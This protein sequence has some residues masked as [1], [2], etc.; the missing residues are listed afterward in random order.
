MGSNRLIVIEGAIGVGK[1]TLAQLLAQELKADLLLEKV[2]ENPFLPKFYED[3]GKWA[4]QTQLFFL[5]SR[6]RQLEELVQQS[7]YA[8]TTITDY[9]F[10]K[11]RIFA[12]MNL[13]EEELVLYEQI[14]KILNPN[15]PKPDLVIFLQAHTEALL[16]RIQQRG[17]VYE[18]EIRPDYLRSLN[19][20]YNRFFF[21]YDE[22]PLLVVETS[23]IDFVRNR[24]DLADLVTQVKQMRRGKEYYHPTR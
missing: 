7:L 19:D 2:E 22:S 8:D 23:D 17:R 21:H 12:Y 4:F 16:D 1:T 9:F 11:D 20:A 24:A 15:I 14:Y 3:P 5:L 10:P 18:K 6:A 13:R